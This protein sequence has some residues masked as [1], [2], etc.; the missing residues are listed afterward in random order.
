MIDHAAVALAGGN[1]TKIPACGHSMIRALV[2]T[3]GVSHMW[4]A[5]DETGALVGFTVFVLP[6]QT[7]FS[8]CEQVHT[9]TLVFTNLMAIK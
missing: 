5:R 4:T 7:L 1:A 2:L 9:A 6:G 3:A 8:T